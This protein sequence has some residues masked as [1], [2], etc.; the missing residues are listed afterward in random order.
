MHCQVIES[1]DRLSLYLRFCKISNHDTTNDPE[2]NKLAWEKTF[3]RLLLI[4]PKNKE[5]CELFVNVANFLYSHIGIV[6]R[7]EN[8]ED[9]PCKIIRKNV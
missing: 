8:N 9:E 1:L 3:V 4:Q 7:E 6:M 2:L 5:D